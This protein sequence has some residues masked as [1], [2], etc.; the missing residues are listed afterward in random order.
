MKNNTLIKFLVLPSMFCLCTLASA[1]SL[2]K[3]V[4]NIDN[5]TLKIENNSSQ[6]LIYQSSVHNNQTRDFNLEN[7]LIKPHT[8]TYFHGDATVSEETPNGLG[9]TIEFNIKDTSQPFIIGDSALG[10]NHYPIIGFGVNNSFVTSTMSNVTIKKN[11]M[12]YD[13]AIKSATITINDK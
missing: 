10:W 3:K 1:T 11:A 6:I 2:L 8:T 12:S 7:H 5:L 13:L 4:D 9:G